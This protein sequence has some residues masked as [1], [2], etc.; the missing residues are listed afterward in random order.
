MPAAVFEEILYR[1]YPLERLS[2]LTGRRWVA[3]ALTL[4]LFV[5]PHLAFFGPEWLLYQGSG[6]AMLYILF[7][8]RRNLVANMLLHLCVNLPILIPTIASR[9]GSLRPPA[10]GA[11]AGTGGAPRPATEGVHNSC[12]FP[13]VDSGCPEFRASQTPAAHIAGV[14][15]ARSGLGPAGYRTPLI[16]RRIGRVNSASMT[17]ST[18]AI[19]PSTPK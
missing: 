7:L 4:P 1:G 14:V 11:S 5:A 13:A 2:E 15:L 17:P 18:I 12:K 6:T 19:P 16:S 3:V 10:N 8:W 9:L